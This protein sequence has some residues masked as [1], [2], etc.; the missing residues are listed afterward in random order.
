M[1]LV[2]YGDTPFVQPETLEK[3]QEA[4]T[5]HDLVVLGFEAADPARYGR[6]ILQGDHLDR[7]VEYKDAS[8]E[9]RA[10]T[11]FNS[12]V[13]AC[14]SDLL[15]DLI[16]AGSNALLLYFSVTGKFICTVPH[17]SDSQISTYHCQYFRF[18]FMLL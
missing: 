18:T 9:E 5:R 8:D 14:K 1:A 3:M 16:D 12:G 17:V 11:L 4:L 6:L 10:I 7:I 15:F 2:L 13:I